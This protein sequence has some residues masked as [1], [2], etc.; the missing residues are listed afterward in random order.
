MHPEQKLLLAVSDILRPLHPHLDEL[1]D[2]ALKLAQ[3]YDASP[4]KPVKDEPKSKP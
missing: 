4:A 1:H 3:S 2:A